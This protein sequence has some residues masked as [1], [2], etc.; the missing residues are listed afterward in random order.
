MKGKDGLENRRMGS[1]GAFHSGQIEHERG[2]LSITE[3]VKAKCLV[4][5]HN[6]AKANQ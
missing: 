6:P 1:R 2:T 5:H 3:A 4:P